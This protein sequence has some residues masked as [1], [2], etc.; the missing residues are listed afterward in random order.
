MPE[1][2]NA[3]NLLD[4]VGLNRIL[5]PDFIAQVDAGEPRE[6][7]RGVWNASNAESLTNRMLEYDWK[8]TLADSDLPKVRAATQFAGVRVGYPFLSRELTDLSLTLPAEWK[9]RGLTLRWFFKQALKDFLPKPILRKKKHGFGLPFG[10]WLLK[11]E[12]LRELVDDALHGIANRGV[13]R[14]DLVEDLTGRQLRQA[15][16]FYG[17]LVWVLAMLE[18]WLRASGIQTLSRTPYQSTLRREWQAV[19]AAS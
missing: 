2:M 3:F 9:V 16:S 18:L 10:T 11:H 17:E 14:R 12:A 13:V 6:R 7:Q 8:F 15:P 4:Y 19:G 5:E 1:R